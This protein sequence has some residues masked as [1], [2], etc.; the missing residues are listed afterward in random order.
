MSAE[1]RTRIENSRMEN[2]ATR[3][4]GPLLDPEIDFPANRKSS[5]MKRLP[6]YSDVIGVL[7][8]LLE[9]QTTQRSYRNAFTEVKK[10]VY[11][12]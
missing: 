2:Q 6:L 11:S 3:M 4:S 7:R 5:D 12:K 9:D 8:Y 1:V 10:M